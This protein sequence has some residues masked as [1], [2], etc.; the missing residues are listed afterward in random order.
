[1][2]E[3]LPAGSSRHDE[4][5][6]KILERLAGEGY[7]QNTQQFVGCESHFLQISSFVNI[8]CSMEN[9]EKLTSHACHLTLEDL[10]RVFQSCSKLSEL[11]ILVTDFEMDQDVKN[12][13]RPGFQR[14]R[15]FFIVCFM[16]NF[17]WPVIQEMLT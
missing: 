12:Q 1:M 6:F 2:I 16:D 9:L 17:S 13:L 8:M 3:R 5:L 10:A 14:L 4:S 15:R 11:N 7:L